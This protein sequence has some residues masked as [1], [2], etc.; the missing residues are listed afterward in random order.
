[1]EAVVELACDEDV[2]AVQP[3]LADALAD[4]LLVSVHLGGVDVPVAD[5]EGGLTAARSRPPRSGTRRTQ[6]RDVLAV[7]QCDDR[8][9]DSWL[10]SPPRVVVHLSLSLILYLIHADPGEPMSSLLISTNAYRR[11]ERVSRWYQ[12]TT[13]ARGNQRK[14]N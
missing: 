6:L 9:A 12:V 10:T 8:N 14:C 13:V 4:L 1:M 7:V 11:L 2:G 3:G 5:L